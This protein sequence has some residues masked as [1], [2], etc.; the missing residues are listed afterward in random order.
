MTRL[1]LTTAQSFLTYRAVVV[2]QHERTLDEVRQRRVLVH[3]KHGL[4]QRE[5]SLRDCRRWRNR[6]DDLGCLTPCGHLG[7]MIVCARTRA[8]PP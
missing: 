3:A 4:E 1:L 2:A 6:E 7:A 8:H 5:E